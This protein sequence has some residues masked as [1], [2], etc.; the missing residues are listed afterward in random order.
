MRLQHHQPIYNPHSTM[1]N[2]HR[3]RT[4]HLQKVQLRGCDGLLLGQPGHLRVPGNGSG[5]GTG[6]G[7][8]GGVAQTGGHAEGLPLRLALGPGQRRPERV[9]Q[10]A[11]GYAHYGHVVGGHHGYGYHLA[12][13]DTYGC[14]REFG[15]GGLMNRMTMYFL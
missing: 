4:N 13:S 8:L 9:V 15:T 6:T 2:N 3:T 5:T 14:G 7:Q 1:G 11:Q 12:D 10:I